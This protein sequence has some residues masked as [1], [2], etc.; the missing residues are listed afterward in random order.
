MGLKENGYSAPQMMSSIPREEPEKIRKWREE[1][2][3]RLE[4]KGTIHI[5][6][7]LAWFS[8]WYFSTDEE[9]ERKKQEMKEA[10]RKELEDWYKHHKETIEKTRSANRLVINIPFLFSIC[11]IHFHFLMQPNL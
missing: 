7:L 8:L 4:K 2:K 5:E 11:F 9:E 1:Q 10:A 6:D 3:L